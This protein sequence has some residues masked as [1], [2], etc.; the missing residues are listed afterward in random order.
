MEKLNGNQ[1]QFCT[2]G[3]TPSIYGPVELV[4]GGMGT[5]GEDSYGLL[6]VKG[7]HLK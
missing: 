1:I 7:K 6:G 4:R 3:V 2:E 5:S